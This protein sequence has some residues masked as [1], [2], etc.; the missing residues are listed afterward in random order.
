MFDSWLSDKF[1]ITAAIAAFVVGC[2]TEVLKQLG[3][4]G[5]H[6]NLALAT[7]CTAKSIFYERLYEDDFDGAFFGGLF[8]LVLVYF[9]ALSGFSVAGW[10]IASWLG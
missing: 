6:L 9:V 8:L 3:I 4:N 1:F 5:N 2:S 10:L 7:L